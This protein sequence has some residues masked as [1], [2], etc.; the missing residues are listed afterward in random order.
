MDRDNNNSGLILQ[1]GPSLPQLPDG[2][3]SI[4][5]SGYAVAIDGTNVVRVPFGVRHARR[6]RP[7][8]PDHWATLVIPFQKLG[9]PSPPPAAA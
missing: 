1:E 7:Q 5:R 2:L 8:K 6:S 3:D 4:F 9:N